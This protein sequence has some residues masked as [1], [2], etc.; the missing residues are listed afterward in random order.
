[1]A[2]T[3]A[4]LHESIDRFW[5]IALLVRSTAG[6]TDDGHGG[7]RAP[8]LLA[9]CTRRQPFCPPRSLHVISDASLRR[10]DRWIDRPL[11]IYVQVHER[12]TRELEI[13][14]S[15]SGASSHCHWHCQLATEKS[16]YAAISITISRMVRL[17]LLQVLVL[18]LPAYLFD[19]CCNVILNF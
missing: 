7:R 9:C 10:I 14:L 8:S 18:P 13:D 15:T 16:S 17:L 1:M 11:C 6:G 2:W 3:A 19:L 5:E 12:L 4:A